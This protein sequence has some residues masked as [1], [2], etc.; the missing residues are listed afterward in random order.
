MQ[1]ITRHGLRVTPQQFGERFSMLQQ[2]TEAHDFK[3]QAALVRSLRSFPMPLKLLPD[4]VQI[5]ATAVK[6]QL[7]QHLG[8][9]PEQTQQLISRHPIVLG[10]R[11]DSLVRKATEQGRLL[12]LEAA[13]VVVQLWIRKPSQMCASMQA[14][15]EKL[16][17]LQQLMQPYMSPADV[18]QLALSN[19]GLLATHTPQA[20][21]GRL[22]VL[23]DCLPD[24]TPQQ[25]GAALIPYSSVLG[26]SPETIRYKWG[27]VT[28]YRDMFMLVTRQ[29]Q[30][31]QQQEQPQ[32]ASELRLLERTAERYA[33]LEYI[34]MQQQQQQQEQQLSKLVVNSTGS[35]VSDSS[36][37]VMNSSDGGAH[38]SHMPPM[39]KVL[40]CRKHLFERL[41]QEHY[42][43]FRQWYKQ[44]QQ[45]QQQAVKRQG[46]QPE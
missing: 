33:L 40:Q 18:R 38:S 46:L 14:L 36:Q 27:V 2:V 32:Q 42:P 37:G 20:V 5:K 24:L 22:E 21:R 26:R 11:A 41:L 30:E 4:T 9:P 44:R 7:L 6:Q 34:M 1:L 15:R 19:L 8:I 13:D 12:D 31:Q 3:Q 35:N 28:Q 43:G 23:Q 17:Q 45:Q 29:Q 16:E 25:L 39:L 10:Y